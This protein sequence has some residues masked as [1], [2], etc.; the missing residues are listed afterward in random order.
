M[1][2]PRTNFLLNSVLSWPV[3]LPLDQRQWPWQ[4]SKPDTLPSFIHEGKA[5]KVAHKDLPSEVLEPPPHGQQP[6]LRVSDGRA[7][8]GEACKCWRQGCARSGSCHRGCEHGWLVLAP[9]AGCWGPRRDEHRHHTLSSPLPGAHPAWGGVR[10][11]SVA[12]PG[13]NAGSPPRFS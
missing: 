12:R 10:W 2:K 11:K 9:Q 8:D 6:A 3:L 5:H 13:E 4:M 7:P 1:R